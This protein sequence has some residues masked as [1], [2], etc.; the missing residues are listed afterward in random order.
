LLLPILVLVFTF[1]MTHEVGNTF[2]IRG[3]FFAAGL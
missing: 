1:L 3:I 2:M